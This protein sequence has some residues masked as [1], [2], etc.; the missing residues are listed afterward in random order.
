MSD[1]LF[2]AYLEQ[3]KEIERLKKVTKHAIY[4]PP[5]WGNSVHEFAM[6]YWESNANP[7]GMVMLYE[8]IKIIPVDKKHI[9]EAIAFLQKMKWS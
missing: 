6:K 4:E 8:G 9:D 2:E 3:Q 5:P 1:K 7:P